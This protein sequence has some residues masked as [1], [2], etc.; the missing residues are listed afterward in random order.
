MLVVDGQSQTRV[1]KS[2]ATQW[3]SHLSPRLVPA[4]VPAMKFSIDDLQVIFPYDKI[5]PGA[6]IRHR[7]PSAGTSTHARTAQSNT[8]TSAT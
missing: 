3:L 6:S 8:R 1:P 2:R 5:Y 7:A 4:L